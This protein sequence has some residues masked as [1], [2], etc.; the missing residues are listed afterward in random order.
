[1][2]KATIPMSKVGQ[3]AGGMG[4]ASFYVGLLMDGV[5]VWNYTKDPNSPNAVHPAKAGVNTIM[6]AMGN[7]GGTLMAIPSSLY[8]GIDAFYTRSGGGW[9]GLAID[10]ERLYRDNKAINPNYQAFPGAMKL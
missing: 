8:F 1:M 4:E 9:G 10:Q 6:G 7:Y 3:W 5:G 2:T